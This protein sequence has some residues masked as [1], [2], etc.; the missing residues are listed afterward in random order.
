MSGRLAAEPPATSDPENRHP[1]AFI[2]TQRAE[3]WSLAKVTV[4]LGWIWNKYCDAFILGVGAEKHVC[5]PSTTPRS[6]PKQRHRCY[7]EN[8]NLKGTL[9]VSLLHSTPSTAWERCTYYHHQWSM[10]LAKELLGFWNLQFIPCE[11]DYKSFRLLSKF[12]Q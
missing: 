1:S 8:G 5:L 4:P 12:S 3:V 2:P 9:M 6:M 10:E 11:S 7:G